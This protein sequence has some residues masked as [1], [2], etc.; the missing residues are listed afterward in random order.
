MKACT[1][2]FNAAMGLVVAIFTVIKKLH[3]SKIGTI[4]AFF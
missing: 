3:H 1:I 4:S 2:Y